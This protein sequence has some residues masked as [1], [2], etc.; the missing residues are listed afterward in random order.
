MLTDYESGL[1]FSCLENIVGRVHWD[2]REAERL[3]G[4]MRAHK[5]VL[6]Q[7]QGANALA[8]WFRTD[9]DL[10]STRE[11]RFP[12]PGDA[13]VH[14]GRLGEVIGHVRRAAGEAALDVGARRLNWLGERLGLSRM[15]LAVLEALARYATHPVI[16]DLIDT[17][18]AQQEWQRPLVLPRRVLACLIGTTPQVLW[19]RMAVDSPLVRFGL[20]V[21][22]DRW[23]VGVGTHV[24]HLTLVSDGGQGV[25]PSWLK[26][27]PP[28][29]FELSD[30]E[31]LGQDR[32]DAETILGSAIE[33]GE[34]GVNVLIHGPAGTGK[35]GFCTALAEQVE[36]DIYCVGP[37]GTIMDDGPR[38]RIRTLLLAQSL[39]GNMGRAALLA[40]G[41]DGLFA[42]GLLTERLTRLLNDTP[43]PMLWT[44]TD[45]SR[46]APDVLRQMAFAVRMRPALDLRARLWVKALARQGVDTTLRDARV[47][48]QDYDALPSVTA[49][50][51]AAAGGLG[52]VA[53]SIQSLGPLLV[54]RRR[55]E[56]A[57]VRLRSFKDLLPSFVERLNALRQGGGVVSGVATGYEELDRLT[58]GL[59]RGALVIVAGRPSMGKSALVLNIAERAA[60]EQKQSVA[61][62]SLELTKEQV[63]ARMLSLIGRVDQLRVRTGR[64]TEEDWGRINSA[65]SLASNARIFIDDSPGLTATE[66]RDRLWRLKHE[67]GLGL[68]VVD[69]LQRIRSGTDSEINRATLVAEAVRSLKD[70]AKELDVPVIAVSQLNRQL[71]RRSDKQPILSDLWGSGAIEDHADVILFMYRDEV[72]DADSPHKGIVDIMVGKHRNGPMGSFRLKFD[73]KFA[74]FDNDGAAE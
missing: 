55:H 53:R 51:T 35:G 47:L 37:S 46:I 10:L 23:G 20:A 59:Q 4:W 18:F 7:G 67:Q 28:S 27:M 73:T 49:A 21:I 57:S 54:R 56:A 36:I 68:V 22:E 33:G 24:R 61:I 5:N 30:F 48:A 52:L 39:V 19:D 38:D 60:I 74:R 72:Y 16:G 43:I 62:F 2:D 69:S 1:V 26:R 9:A 41:M 66:L 63:Q 14:W 13:S 6:L 40:D 34:R 64:L 17:V 8:R 3:I 31:Y 11:G 29:P 71:E 44:A 70:M 32:V 45:T 42:E 25:R 65:I 58:G 12:D 50:A 15:D